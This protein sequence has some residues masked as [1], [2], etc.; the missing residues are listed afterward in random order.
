MG[1]ESQ[2]SAKHHQQAAR[3]GAIPIAVVTVSDSRTF[4][5]DRNG[6]YL[7]AEI[8]RAGHTL[9]GYRIIPDEPALVVSAAKELAGEGGARIVLFNG[10]TGIS[11]RDNTFDALS[12]LLEKTLPGFGELFRML[13]WQQVGAAAMLSRATAGVYRGSV[14]ISTPGSPAAVQ[15]AWEKL[16]LPEINHLA[17]ELGR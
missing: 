8:E 10:G 12:A 15:L 13:S 5:D 7:T 4:E 6:L 9:A 2:S 1:M 3:E 16:I 17:W 14:I 11:S